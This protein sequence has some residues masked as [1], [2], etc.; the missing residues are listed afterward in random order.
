MGKIIET[1]IDRHDG[2]ITND[3][4]DPA[5]NVYRYVANFDIITSPKRMTP[6]RSSEDGHSAPTRTIRNYAI[7]LRSGNSTFAL[8][9]LGIGAAGTNRAEIFYKPLTTTSADLSDNGWNSLT[10]GLSAN[11]NTNFNLF[12]YYTRVNRL[13]GARGGTA[14][15]RCDPTDSVAFAETYQSLTYTE[16]TQGLVHPKDDILY[17]GYYNA[18]GG[19]GAKSFIFKDNNG[20]VNT[21]AL[22]LPDELVPTS[23]SSAG[24]Y[25][26][27]LCTPSSGVGNSRLYLWDRNESTTT[28]AETIDV[29][30]GSGVICGELDGEVIVILQR[31][32]VG[33]SFTNNPAGII[34]H[35]DRV[36]FK[37]IVGNVAV[38]FKILLADAS[39]A[40]TTYIPL[41]K[42]IHDNR[43]YFQML[44]HLNGAIRDGVWSIGRLG[45]NN[46][47]A[48][49]HE[50]TSN[51]NTA[52]VDNDTLRGFFFVGD[53]LFQS[54]TTGGGTTAAVSKTD[55]SAN[56]SHN[57][58]AETKTMNGR[59]SSDPSIDASFYKDLVEVSALSEYMPAA[60][61]VAVAYQVD[62]GIGT[63][64]WTT[65]FTNT[66][67]SSLG[68][69][70][71]NIESSGA[72]LPKGYKEIAFKIT[73]TGG[74]EITGLR[75]KEEVI[76]KKYIAD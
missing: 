6:Y 68:H 28:L 59:Q 35:R 42:Q 23:I 10:N 58:T 47:F 19:A 2:G 44:I 17:F 18:A 56:Y 32:G 50:R 72:A 8:Y 11:N 67:D 20:T 38:T 52:L 54:Y 14:I 63:G 29:G 49:I 66:T 60:G 33:A 69:T 62:E 1:L 53:Y 31:G 12:V 22:T 41:Y 64:T 71:N 43:L 3:P 9:G 61:S 37:K 27:I 13:Y 25:L 4:R 70:A 40:N 26:A 48:L 21:T 34:S 55:N 39:Q 65:I 7:G 75:F 51:N 15:W 74:A 30:A 45:P 36:I 73:S 76:G 5:G 46:E 24:N 57:S 16:I